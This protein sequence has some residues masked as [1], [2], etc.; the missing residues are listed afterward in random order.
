[1]SV[2]SWRANSDSTSS[3]SVKEEKSK[4][5]VSRIRRPINTHALRRYAEANQ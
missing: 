2:N 4:V 1:M 5:G 3:S